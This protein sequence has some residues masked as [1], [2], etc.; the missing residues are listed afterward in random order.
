MA[1]GVAEPRNPGVTLCLSKATTTIVLSATS[2]AISF[3]LAVLA[4]SSRENRGKDSGTSVGFVVV[5]VSA[6]VALIEVVEP[7][8][9]AGGRTLF[10]SLHAKRNTIIVPR[11]PVVHDLCLEGSSCVCLPWSLDASP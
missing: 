9:I 3:V 2:S 7:L 11:L 10:K 6:A 4:Q 8:S 5:A 1:C